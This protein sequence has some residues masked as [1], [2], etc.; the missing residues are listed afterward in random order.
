MEDSTGMRDFALLYT[1]AWCSQNPESV[2]AFF[3]TDGSLKVNDNDP[4]WGTA[5]ITEVAREFMT[6]F[7]D[8][9]LKMDALESEDDRFVYHWTFIG[10]NDGPGGTGNKVCFSGYEKW[11][12]NDARLVAESLGHFDEQEYERQVA[13]GV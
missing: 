1:A 13:H 9:L 12:M 5:A 7:P 2:A 3:A 11:R 10:T 4:A 6:A 8:L